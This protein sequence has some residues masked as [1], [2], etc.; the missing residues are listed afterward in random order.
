MAYILK[1]C[2][3]KHLLV[4]HFKNSMCESKENVGKL[5]GKA[6]NQTKPCTL[7]HFTKK[8]SPLQ[9]YGPVLVKLCRTVNID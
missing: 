3:V 8:D 4:K 7:R 5:I 2:Y 6:T 9:K 1:V